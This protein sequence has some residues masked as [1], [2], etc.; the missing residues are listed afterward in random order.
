LFR[1]RLVIAWRAAPKQST[2][3]AAHPKPRLRSKFPNRRGG[4]SAPS[5]V[6][7]SAKSKK[8]TGLIA[9]TMVRERSDDIALFIGRTIG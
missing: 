5:G 6:T 1:L 8:S 9:E 7:F 4:G 2:D 3:L